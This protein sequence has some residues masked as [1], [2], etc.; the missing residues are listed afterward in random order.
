MDQCLGHFDTL[1]LLEILFRQNIRVGHLHEHCLAHSLQQISCTQ[2]TQTNTMLGL[3][4]LDPPI[5]MV[6]EGKPSLSS[7]IEFEGVC[8][9]NKFNPTPSMCEHALIRAHVCQKW[10]ISFH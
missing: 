7:T 6:S 10:E 2:Q 9:V 3:Q 1:G 4:P 8:R 5:F